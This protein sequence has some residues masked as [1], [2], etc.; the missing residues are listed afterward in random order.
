MMALPLRRRRLLHNKLDDYITL[1]NDDGGGNTPKKQA[2][3][4]L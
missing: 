4:M 3:G 2:K 1:I